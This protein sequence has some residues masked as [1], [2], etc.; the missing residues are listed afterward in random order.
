MATVPFLPAS[1]LDD[2]GDL[3]PEEVRAKLEAEEI[4]RLA[5]VP[6]EREKALVEADH[7]QRYGEIFGEPFVLPF[8]VTISGGGRKA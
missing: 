5:A 1:P 8:P 4:T 3:T 6:F 2:L 7:N